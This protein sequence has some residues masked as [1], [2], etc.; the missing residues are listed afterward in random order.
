MRSIVWIVG[1]GVIG[2]TSFK[3]YHYFFDKVA[4][5]IRLSGMEEGGWYGGDIACVVSGE[6][7]YKIKNVSIFIDNKPL[8]YHF[9]VGKS[10]F[11]YPFIIPSKT[12]PNQKHTLE[13]RAVDSTFNR[14]E[15][16]QKYSFVVDNTPLQAAFV[17]QGGEFRVFQGKTMHVQFQTSKPLKKGVVRLFSKQYFCF[18]EAD[19]S[20]VYE[21]YVPMDCETKPNEYIF[22]IDCWDNVDNV[23]TLEGKVQVVPFPFKKG[24][25]TID[26]A[27]MEEEKMVSESQE[28]LNQ[29]LEELAQKSPQK[30]LWTGSFCAPTEVGRIFTEFGSIRITK[31]KGMYAH[32]GVDIGHLP[33]SGVWACQ[34]GVVIIK[35][36]YH[37]SGNTVAIDH[38][39][40]IISLYFHLD[41]FSE[42]VVVGKAI[43]KGHPIGTVGKTG[44]AA[45]YHLHW[46]LRINDIAVDPMEW[47]VP[48]F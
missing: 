28:L 9:S 39:W 25:V 16:V 47:L 19:D 27:K 13:V 43:K 41:S 32:K 37:F 7:P 31:E 44:Y 15:T 45:G 23:V 34:S 22:V 26:S 1:I 4:P 12:L 18:P 2:Y 24:Q 38:G 14:L 42:S 30:K 11:E 5:V 36:R 29:Q 35:D 21:A 48:G 3:V 17:K 20:L 46:E 10:S 6:H 33:R 40:G 8:T